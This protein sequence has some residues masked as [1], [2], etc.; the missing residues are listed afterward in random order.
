MTRKRA[1]ADVAQI[2]Q[3]TQ[4][5]CCAASIASA[6]HALG[7]PY[8]EDDVNRV[9]GASPMAGASWEAM[10]ATVQYFGC[11]GT[12][13]VPATPRMLKTWTDRGIPVVIAWNPEGRPWSHAS[14]VFDVRED[15]AGKLQVYVMDSNIP[16]PS[17]TVRVL[18]EDTFCQKWGEK[19]SD[20]LIVRRPAMAVELEVDGQGRQVVA[21]SHRGSVLPPWDWKPWAT[22]VANWLEDKLGE[23]P[24]FNIDVITKNGPTP[25][26]NASFLLPAGPESASVFNRWM[27]DSVLSRQ[28]KA[29]KRTWLKWGLTSTRSGDGGF[30]LQD[31]TYVEVDGLGFGSSSESIRVASTSRYCGVYKARDRKWYLEL[32]RYEWGERDD[33]I[34]Y[35]PFDSKQDAEDYLHD[36]FSNPGGI[37]IIDDTGQTAVPV[38]SPNGYPVQGVRWQGRWA[39][40]ASERV[41]AQDALRAVPTLEGDW[42]ILREVGAYD[43]RSAQ[44][45]S[46][47]NV[48]ARKPSNSTTPVPRV[49]LLDGDVAQRIYLHAKAGRKM[50]LRDFYVATLAKIVQEEGL[51]ARGMEGQVEMLAWDLGYQGEHLPNWLTAFAEDEELN[52]D[53]LQEY[54]RGKQEGLL[55]RQAS[56]ATSVLAYHSHDGWIAND[57]PLKLKADASP[58]E[59]REAI[60]IAYPYATSVQSV[61]ETWCNAGSCR[62]H[63]R[64][65][66]PDKGTSFKMTARRAG[67]DPMQVKTMAQRVAD[68]FTAK[69]DPRKIVIPKEDL[70]KSRLG[71]EV[72]LMQKRKTRFDDN[73]I[74]YA[75]GHG[76]RQKH[77]KDFRQEAD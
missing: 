45:N 19:V 69:Q 46:P 6:L 39:R 44:R 73:D 51:E 64:P 21:S 12:L 33:A 15:V 8:S 54:A 42:V 9:L 75:R 30:R 65:F 24:T 28:W 53:L 47:V 41:R 37:D 40:T 7:K 77:R 63:V 52:L 70:P 58:Q 10:L 61:D 1:K 74:D 49:G 32:A 43:G 59:L 50:P 16:N 13:V 71:P 62:V 76:R 68:A 4:F 29:F 17:E 36:N 35:G 72:L 27:N 60:Q 5:T 20:S 55:Q 48:Y 34:T 23:R 11:R 25:Y 2:R 3:T 14:T 18:D 31:G 38:K 56:Y 26:Y 57:R 22:A 67:E 66:L